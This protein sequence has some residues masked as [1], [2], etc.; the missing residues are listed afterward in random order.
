[1]IFLIDIRG[2]SL[3]YISMVLAIL[4]NTITI[5]D[6]LVSHIDNYLYMHFP[7]ISM[8]NNL[9][10]LMNLIKSLHA[11]IYTS[12]TIAGVTETFETY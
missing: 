11:C 4:D 1:M 2:D 3:A 8:K 9:N 6:H 5:S 7:C 12:R 10:I